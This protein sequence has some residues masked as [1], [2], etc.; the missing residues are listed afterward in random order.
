MHRSWNQILEEMEE[1]LKS[2]FF[3]T[4]RDSTRP[5]FNPPLVTMD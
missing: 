2:I 4:N 3:T 5:V 1:F